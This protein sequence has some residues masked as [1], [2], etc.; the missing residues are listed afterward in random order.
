MIPKENHKFWDHLGWQ[1]LVLASGGKS[2]ACRL[3]QWTALGHT[4]ADI[5]ASLCEPPDFYF[6]E[7][8]T[9]SVLQC[10]V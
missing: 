7:V 4:W 6:S 3:H 5:L 8:Y 10:T 9:K 2:Q 1:V